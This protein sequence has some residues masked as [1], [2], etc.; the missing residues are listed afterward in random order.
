MLWLQETRP[1]LKKKYPGVS[2]TELSKKAGEAWKGITDKAVSWCGFNGKGIHGCD[3][4]HCRNGRQ[5]QGVPKQ[6]IM[7]K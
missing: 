2:I 6:D 1:S 5:R 7:S 3:Q 4:L